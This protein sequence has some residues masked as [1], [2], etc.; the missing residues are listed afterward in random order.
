MNK[1]I[2]KRIPKPEGHHCFA[3]GT[4]NPVGL[5]LDF[6]AEGD[7]VCTDVVLD[8]NRVGWEGIAHGGIISTLLDEVMSWT[9]IF[10]RRVFF[11]TR[12]MEVRY[13]KPV[14]IGVP[15]TARGRMG[16]ETKPPRLNVKGE[17]IDESGRVLARSKGEFAVLSGDKLD[18]RPGE[19]KG[20]MK[21]LFGRMASLQ[22]GES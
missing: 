11:V 1:I 17:L 16:S 9:I 18:M 3:C 12:R 10:F 2:R 6:Y 7:F 20:Q 14:P 19:M 8:G 15:L 5:N 21:E 4:A 22:D 13:L